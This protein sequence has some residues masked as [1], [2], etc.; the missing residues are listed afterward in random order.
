MRHGESPHSCEPK[1]IDEKNVGCGQTTTVVRVVNLLV[2][3]CFIRKG[4]PT[5]RVMKSEFGGS[6]RKY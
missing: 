5:A 3:E 2:G 4:R 1:S 6:R